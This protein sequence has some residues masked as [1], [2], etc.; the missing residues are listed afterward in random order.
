[1]GRVTLCCR[2][3]MHATRNGEHPDLPP[4]VPVGSR[5]S[6][7]IY[8]LSA[9]LSAML[10]Q[11]GAVGACRFTVAGLRCEVVPDDGEVVPADL[12]TEV[13]GPRMRVRASRT[14]RCPASASSSSPRSRKTMA[15]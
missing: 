13:A 14:A 1:M 6:G 12:G 5:E 11:R 8:E 7:L 10:L 4:A 9:D 15:G 3:T 2:I